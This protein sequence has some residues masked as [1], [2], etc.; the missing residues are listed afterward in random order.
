MGPNVHAGLFIIAKYGNNLNV[1]QGMKTEDV[2][3]YSAI[4]K[5][6]I[7]SVAA[8]WLDQRLSQRKTNCYMISQIQSQKNGTN[9]LIYK[10]EI[11][12][13]IE[14]KFIK[15]KRKGRNKLGDWD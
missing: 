7:M 8:T 1:H 5:N 10:T 12:T 9:E 14:N 2:V 3:Y 11:V 13:D 15:V 4:K 6:E